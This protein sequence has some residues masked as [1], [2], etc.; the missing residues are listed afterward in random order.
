MLGEGMDTN[1]AYEYKKKLEKCEKEMM[2]LNKQEQLLEAE[3]EEG[4][5]KGKAEE[6]EERE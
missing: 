2:E 6:K 3:R 1:E 5:G 4:K